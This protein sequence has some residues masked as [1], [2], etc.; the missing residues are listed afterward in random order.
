MLAYYFIIITGC[1]MI[2]LCPHIGKPFTTACLVTDVNLHQGARKGCGTIINE[3]FTVA[4]N[5]VHL[6]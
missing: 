1:Y 2:N 3:H 5:Y 6:Q 4:I